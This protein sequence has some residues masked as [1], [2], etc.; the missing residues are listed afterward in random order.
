MITCMFFVDFKPGPTGQPQTQTGLGMN[1]GLGRALNT[2]LPSS[3]TQQTPQTGQTGSA[4][5]TTL[6]AALGGIQMPQLGGLQVQ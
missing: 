4:G 2:G 1:A 5:P 3:G 6:T